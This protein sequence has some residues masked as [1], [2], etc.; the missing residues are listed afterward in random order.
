[1]INATVAGR[2]AKD[3]ELKQ[4][5]STT[6]CEFSVPHQPKKDGP[7]TWVRC[8]IFGKRGESLSRY[9]TKGTYVSAVGRLT[10]REYEGK[11]GKAFSVELAVDDIALLGGGQRDEGGA[12]SYGSSGH[13]ASAKHTGTPDPDYGGVDDVPF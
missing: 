1:M 7:T 6:V 9:L 11:N 13:G 10:V 3:A 8:A 2:I 12:S 5:G 4:A